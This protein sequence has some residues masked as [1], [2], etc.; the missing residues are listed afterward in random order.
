MR[1]RSRERETETQMKIALRADQIREE[2]KETEDRKL[3]QY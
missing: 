2:Q 3:Q 1:V